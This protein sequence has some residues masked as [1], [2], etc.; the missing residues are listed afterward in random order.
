MPPKHCI[1]LSPYHLTIALLYHLTTVLLNHLTPLSMLLLALLLLLLTLLLLLLPLLIP[2][3]IYRH[4]CSLIRL[5]NNYYSSS[6]KSRVVFYWHRGHLS[7]G[8][9]VTS[10]KI[11]S[12]NFGVYFHLFEVHVA[13]MQELAQSR[14]K[15]GS[16]SC[17][18]NPTKE[19]FHAQKTL[20]I[21]R[22]TCWTTFRSQS[23]FWRNQRSTLPGRWSAWW[24]WR[25]PRWP[26]ADLISLHSLDKKS[27]VQ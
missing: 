11:I 5:S 13:Q 2:P 6:N 21:E 25:P 14:T 9:L 10:K 7:G 16:R 20:R 19:C 22:R 27:L 15:Q 4:R 26:P 23:P 17:P 3:K 12:H 8:S 24:T 1:I 18:T